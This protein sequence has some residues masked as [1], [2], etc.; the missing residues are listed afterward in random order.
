MIL[1]VSLEENEIRQILADHLSRVF[2]VE[3]SAEDLPIEV[4]SKQNYKSEWERA[5]IRI[6]TQVIR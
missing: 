3:I 1:H 4:K 6:N 5:A 2:N